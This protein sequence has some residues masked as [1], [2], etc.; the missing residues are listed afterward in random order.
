MAVIQRNCR[1]HVFLRGWQ[2]WRL[3]TKVKPLLNVAHTEEELKKKE[4]EVCHYTDTIPDVLSYNA[5]VDDK[6]E[7]KD[8]QRGTG[9]QRNGGQT[10]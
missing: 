6:A 4:G 7:G 5:C 3:F 2:W 10:D 8:C 9:S 1:K